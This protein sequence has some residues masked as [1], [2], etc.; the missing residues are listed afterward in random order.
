MR[1]ID[2]RSRQTN[3]PVAKLGELLHTTIQDTCERL[4]VGVCLFMRSRVAVLDEGLVTL[5]ALKRLF[6]GMSSC[7]RL[8]RVDYYGV[9]N[10]RMSFEHTIPS[11]CQV[12]ERSA[13]AFKLAFLSR[14]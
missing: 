13:T 8:G 1:R 5:T 11:S 14:R 3:L 7:T 9:L 12:R 6:A 4:R 10:S 2:L